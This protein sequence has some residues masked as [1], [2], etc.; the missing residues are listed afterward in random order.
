MVLCFFFFVSF[1]ISV[2]LRSSSTFLYLFIFIPFLNSLPYTFVSS[3]SHSQGGQQEDA[4]EFFG[5][6]LDTLEE[7]LLAMLAA[8]NAPP[9]VPSGSHPPSSPSTAGNASSKQKNAATSR[10]PP[11]GG[12]ERAPEDGD[13]WLEVGKR[14]RTVVT[15]TVSPEFECACQVHSFIPFFFFLFW[16]GLGLGQIKAT[17]SPITRI[18]GGKFRTT[19]RRPGQKDSVTIEDWR[20]LRLDIQVRFRFR[21]RL[22]SSSFCFVF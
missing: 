7:E 12:E 2:F 15:R 11:V 22:T 16:V 5:F 9:S 1:V 14:N 18:F 8:V 21:F 6:Y 10:G 17:E 4:E 20:S 19:L 3:P 13:G